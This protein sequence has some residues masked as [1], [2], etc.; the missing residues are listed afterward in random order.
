MSLAE[1]DRVLTRKGLHTRAKLVAAARSVFSQTAFA[2]ARI[3]DITAAAQVANGTFYTYFTSKE[4]IFR[5][6]AAEALEALT[7]APRRDPDNTE[8]D[9]ARDVAYASRQF[10]LACRAHARVLRSIEQLSTSD[11]VVAS[12]RRRALVSSAKRAE[13]WIRRLQDQGICDPSLDAWHTAVA[14][15]AMNVSMGYD[16]L[17]LRDRPSD[18]DTLVRTVTRVWAKTVGLE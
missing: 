6:V 11:D 2:E 5:E 14:L 1:G 9:P 7:T 10:F 16:Q 17:V 12:T 4:G 3:T 8:G 18:I 15:Q 13:R